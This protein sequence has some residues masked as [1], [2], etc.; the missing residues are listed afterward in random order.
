MPFLFR[1]FP[2]Q[3]PVTY[4]AGPCIDVPRTVTGHD[5]S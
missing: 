4:M 5:L 2:V 1:H 3:C